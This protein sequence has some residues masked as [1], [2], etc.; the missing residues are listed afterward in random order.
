MSS[1]ESI[2]TVSGSPRPRS[3]LIASKKAASP[4]RV[5]R[6]SLAAELVGTKAALEVV[7]KAHAL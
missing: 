6:V 7:G 3:Y 2:H 1:R 4:E 5:Q